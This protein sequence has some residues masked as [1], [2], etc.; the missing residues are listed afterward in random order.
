ME[1]CPGCN[2]MLYTKLITKDDD[3]KSIKLVNY[4]KNCDY[5]KERESTKDCSVYKRNYD[6]DYAAHKLLIN[7]YTIYDNTLP[8]LCIECVSDNCITN[9]DI[10]NSKS[11]VINN[12]PEI[13]DEINNILEEDTELIEKKIP[14]KLTSIL[15]IL[16]NSVDKTNLMKKY[17]DYQLDDSTKL[18]TSEFIKPIKEV[19]YI[20][21][22]PHNMKYLYMCVNCGTSWLGNTET[23]K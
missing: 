9:L 16:K 5:Q 18:K 20:K 21:Y 2:Y 17:N 11:F 14:I 19:L 8:K 4:C 1:F 15:V 3:T 13:P 23:K 12:V 10:D 6:N 7:K 22:D